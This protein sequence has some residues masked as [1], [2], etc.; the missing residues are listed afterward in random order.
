MKL[1]RESA[2]C[3]KST[4]LHDLHTSEKTVIVNPA[5]QARVNLLFVLCSSVVVDYREVVRHQTRSRH[6]VVL[7]LLRAGWG[8]RLR[9][10]V[11]VVA[12][13]PTDADQRNR[14]PHRNLPVS[15]YEHI[16]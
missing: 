13:Q 14:Q 4:D 16:C 1:Q 15:R 10:D 7:H 2:H 8:P 11:T 9:R 3:T 5:H 12:R 6:R